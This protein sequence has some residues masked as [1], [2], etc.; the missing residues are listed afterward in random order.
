MYCIFIGGASASGKSSIAKHLLK[1]LNELGINATELKMDDYFHERPD[2]IDNDVFRATTNLDVPQ[3]LHLDR[4]NRDITELSKGH[5]I[6]KPLLSFATNKY[7]A[8]EDI[9][10][11]EVVVIEGIFAQ[12]FYQNFVDK[13]LPSILVNVTTESYHDLMNRRIDRDIKE[14]SRTRDVVLSCE[15]KTVGPGF[16]QYTASNAPGADIYIDNKRH[17]DLEERNKALDASVMEIIDHLNELRAGRSVERRARPDVRELVARSHWEAGENSTAIDHSE[18]RFI[19][20]FHGVFGETPG[21]YNRTF[22]HD[23]NMHVLAGF[24]TVLGAAAV[25]V[26]LVALSGALCTAVAVTGAAVALTGL[27]LFAYSACKGSQASTDEENYSLAT[28]AF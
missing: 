9:S 12:Y 28:P 1:K 17:V 10:P 25:A 3:M 27:G 4:L 2:D 16:Y 18:G 13:E 26:A 20:V 15:R 19:G 23:W 7:Y 21:E 5:S 6:R 24:V 14:R 22:S 11:S 8:W